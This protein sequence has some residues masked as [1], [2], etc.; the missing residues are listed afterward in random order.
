MVGVQRYVLFLRFLFGSA[1]DSPEV[2][3]DAPAP[4]G[5]TH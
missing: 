4:Y 5:H 1:C 2:K 3:R